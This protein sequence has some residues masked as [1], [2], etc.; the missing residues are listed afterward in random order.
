MILS[1]RATEKVEISHAAQSR[2]PMIFGFNTDVKHDETV[3]HVQSEARKADLLLQTMVFVKGHCIG[4]FASSYAEQ[5]G[6]PK[7]SEEHIHELLKKQHRGVLDVIQAGSVE[8]FF[9]DQTEIRDAEGESL[10]VTW[11]NSDE[12]VTSKT[13]IMR[14]LVTDSGA[15]V[16]GALV[17]SRLQYPA[18]VPIHSQAVT[19]ADGRVAMDLNLED[20]EAGG[21]R[22][23]V[24]FI[25]ATHGERSVTRKYRLKVESS[26]S[27]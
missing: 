6:N 10:A 12:P 5:V 9:R 2:D 11:L 8:Q 22:D 19:E 4:K 1:R 27:S 17:T 18:G 13:L 14:L 3:Y 21:A 23:P 16:D 20:L 15:P 26:V 7:F 25:R 24:I